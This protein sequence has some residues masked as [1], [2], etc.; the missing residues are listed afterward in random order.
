MGDTSFLSWSKKLSDKPISA[1]ETFMPV[2]LFHVDNDGNRC[3]R[4]NTSQPSYQLKSLE[5][6]KH[7]CDIDILKNFIFTV[8]LKN[9]S[10]HGDFDHVLINNNGH[11]HL[12]RAG[13][14]YAT[15]PQGDFFK[16][17]KKD[18]LR[19]ILHLMPS[20]GEQDKSQHK[21]PDVFFTVPAFIRHLI[22]V[23]EAIPQT[24]VGKMYTDGFIKNNWIFPQSE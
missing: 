17:L 11:W 14:A 13:S 6:I 8:K 18:G 7:E 4:T 10:K 12:N 21:D 5:S 23:A 1:N 16:P 22:A 20:L 24:P 19:R 15:L 3:E 9:G 2:F